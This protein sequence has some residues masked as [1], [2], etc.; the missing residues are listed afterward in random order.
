MTTTELP[1]S[2]A[3]A[4]LRFLENLRTMQGSIEGFVIPPVRMDARSRPYGHSVLPTSFFVALAVALEASSQLQEALQGAKIPLT[5]ADIRDMLRHGEAY[6]PLAEEMERFARGI[7]HTVALR[8]GR[9]GRLS[10]SAYRFAKELNLLEG[11]SLPIPEVE[12]MK[13]A[14][15]ASG[16]RKQAKPA[17]VVTVKTTA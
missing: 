4:A 3:E 14:L 5:P 17:P 11:V 8:R 6:L 2:H 7:R 9:V 10:A 13:R 12:T 15:P 1:I 16:R